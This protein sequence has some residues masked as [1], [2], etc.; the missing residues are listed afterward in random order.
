MYD[1]F[2]SSGIIRRKTPM[3]NC[4]IN[5]RLVKK[6]LF[7]L[8]IY[9]VFLASFLRLCCFATLQP[10]LHAQPL[11]TPRNL[12]WEKMLK[13]AESDG[14]LNVYVHAAYS[15]AVEEFQKVFPKIKLTMSIGA[16]GPE[17]ASRLMGERRRKIW[18]TSTWPGLAPISTSYTRPKL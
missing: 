17:I 5:E 1:R 4:S 9:F 15:Q 13:A 18:Q 10:L 6:F 14:Q 2:H 8:A 11:N 3:P 16:G 7:A 12:E